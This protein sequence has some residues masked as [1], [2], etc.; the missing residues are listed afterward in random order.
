MK[1]AQDPLFFN[2]TQKRTENVRSNAHY[3]F[4]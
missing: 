2:Q 4:V 3:G 1:G